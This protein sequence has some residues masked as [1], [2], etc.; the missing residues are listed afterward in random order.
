MK[1]ANDYSIGKESMWA[2]WRAIP[3]LNTCGSPNVE[4]SCN[5]NLNQKRK[6]VEPVF[7]LV[8]AADEAGSG[9][10]DGG[11]NKQQVGAKGQAPCL[12]L[13]GDYR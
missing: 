5:C 4:G 9:N 8:V 2:G 6:G 12:D 10:G 1:V 11:G 13:R 3:K 7:D